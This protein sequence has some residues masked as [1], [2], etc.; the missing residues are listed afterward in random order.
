MRVLS[1]V[2]AVTAA[3]GPKVHPSSTF[4]VDDPRAGGADAAVAVDGGVAPRDAARP[5][6]VRTGTVTRAAINEVLDA[7]PAELLRGLEVNALRPGDVFRGWQLV[8]FVDADAFAAVD[9]AVGDVLTKINGHTLETPQDL[10]ALWLELYR[11]AAID[12]T[13]DRGGQIV[14]LRFEITD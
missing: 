9:V 8:R 7:G 13:L 3:C 2:L 5:A 4:D 11:A 10:S 1:L 12:A 14:T 6:G